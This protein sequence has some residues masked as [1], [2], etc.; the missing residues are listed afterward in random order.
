MD[1]TNGIAVAI[2]VEDTVVPAGS[3]SGWGTQVLVAVEVSDR[4]DLGTV[5]V[6]DEVGLLAGRYRLVERLGQGGMSIVWRAFDEVL[7]RRV[8]VKVLAGAHD[9]PARERI[10][11]EAQAAARLSHPHIT[12]VHDYGEARD[13][14]GELVPYVVMELV[15]GPTLGERLKA[16]PL[17]VRAALLICAQVASALAAAHARGLVHRDIKPSNVMLSPAGAKVMDFGVAAVVGEAGES[18][19]G[20]FWGTPAYLAP[21]RLSTGEVVPAS[22]VYALGL[23]LY[24]LLAGRQPWQ[25]DTVTDMLVAHQYIEPAPL[26]PL[27]GVAERVGSLCQQ[28]LAKRPEDRPSAGEV[29]AE[30]VDALGGVLAGVTAAS[31]DGDPDTQV[32][33]RRRVPAAVALGLA[34]HGAPRARAGLPAQPVLARGVAVAEA[35]PPDDDAEQPDQRAQRRRHLALGLGSTLA[36]LAILLLLAFC[37]PTNGGRGGGTDEP[38][39]QASPGSSESVNPGTGHPTPGTAAPTGGVVGAG[40]HPGDPT[41]SAGRR[42][43]TNAPSPV[44]RSVTTPGGS[45]T[46]RCTGPTAYLVSW[47]PLPGFDPTQINRGPGATVGLTFQGPVTAIRI[48]FRCNNGTPL[49]T[50]ETL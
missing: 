39:P 50:V 24:R 37:V 12:N 8:A 30:L 1:V 28:C 9:P 44:E 4:T 47:S 16:G 29:A 31:T 7:T 19:T 49:A 43:P 46:C 27:D 36:A 14:S 11:A 17:P 2:K 33:P 48:T 3:G 40:E 38:G 42:Q 13:E 34:L 6:V 23:L 20:V 18:S 45:A 10:R 35:D 41:G 25:A 5:A 22:D 32:V 26:P 15:P 21:E